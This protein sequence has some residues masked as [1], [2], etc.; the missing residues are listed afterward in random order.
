MTVLYVEQKQISSASQADQIFGCRRRRIHPYCVHQTH[1]KETDLRRW[2]AQKLQPTLYR[3]PDFAIVLKTLPGFAFDL[4][5]KHT[6]DGAGW[7]SVCKQF[8][9][10]SPSEYC[11][12][13]LWQ[14]V[15]SIELLQTSRELDQETGTAGIVV[16]TVL[17]STENFRR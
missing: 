5:T 16:D 9:A 10:V 14:P 2:E 17:R 12:C 1:Q 3:H 4:G 13:G 11:I 15:W 6:K 7:C 8:D